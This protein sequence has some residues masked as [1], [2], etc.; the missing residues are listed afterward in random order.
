M[1]KVDYF[2]LWEKQKSPPKFS[3]HKRE[4]TGQKEA[5][6]S[7]NSRQQ[8]RLSLTPNSMEYEL[9]VAQRRA[10]LTQ[11]IEE[12]ERF[13]NGAVNNTI[14]MDSDMLH[15]RNELLRAKKVLSEFI[16]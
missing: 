10:E 6:Y 14:I 8:E 1:Q 12:L 13:K 9:F 7:V 3:F 5:N 16:S 2:G 15:R 11:L 4:K